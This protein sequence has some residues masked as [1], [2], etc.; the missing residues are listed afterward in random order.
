MSIGK[1]NVVIEKVECR[2]G[3]DSW[4]MRL[5]L[6]ATVRRLKRIYV[7]L[8]VAGVTVYVLSRDLGADCLFELSLTILLSRLGRIDSK[9][10]LE[11]KVA[12]W[13]KKKIF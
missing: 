7:M 8:N 2:W 12:D 10:P 9:K 3:D 11:G 13:V 1:R 5:P 6:K 4:V